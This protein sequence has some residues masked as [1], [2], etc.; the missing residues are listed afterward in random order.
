VV[1]PDEPVLDGQPGRAHHPAVE[2]EASSSMRR[3]AVFALFLMPIPNVTIAFASFMSTCLSF[4]SIRTISR[5]VGLAERGLDLVTLP[6]R[7][8]SRALAGRAR[9]A[10]AICG[11]SP[12]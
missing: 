1:V 2:S 8:L 3:I 4:K 11:R 12:A 10:V 7:D 5:E 9:R 6:L